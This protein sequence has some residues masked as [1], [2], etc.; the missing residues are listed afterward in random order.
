MGSPACCEP[1][2]AGTVGGRATPF[3]AAAPTA[4]S[5]TGSPVAWCIDETAG[6]ASSRAESKPLPP[7]RPSKSAALSTS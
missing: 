3:S 6:A 4:G 5:E 1:P 7:S 2:A